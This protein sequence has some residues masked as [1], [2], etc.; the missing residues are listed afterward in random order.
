MPHALVMSFVVVV[1]TVK[2]LFY[3][4]TCFAALEESIRVTMASIYVV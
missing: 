4:F 3:Y 2:E 1:I